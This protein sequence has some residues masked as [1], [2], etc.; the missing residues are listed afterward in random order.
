MPLANFL[1]VWIF[2]MFAENLYFVALNL[3]LCVWNFEMNGNL[4]AG[5][6]W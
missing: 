2:K 5:V 1:F 6:T 3:Y 4:G